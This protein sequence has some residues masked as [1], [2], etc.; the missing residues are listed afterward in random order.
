MRAVEQFLHTVDADILNRSAPMHDH[1]SSPLRPLRKRLDAVMVREVDDNLLL[2]DTESNRIHQLNH[3]AGRIWQRCDTASPDAI[4]AE[5]A[6]DYD[7][8]EV[9]ALS[10][11]VTMLE[12]FRALNLVVDS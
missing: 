7:V 2:L 8:G 11:V 12:R 4:A 10:D 9:Q 1:G 5:L 6:R 3:T